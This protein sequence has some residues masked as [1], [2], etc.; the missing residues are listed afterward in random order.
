MTTAHLVSP[1]G[2]TAPIGTITWM[3]I[4]ATTNPVTQMRIVAMLEKVMLADVPVIPVTES[5][6]WYEYDTKSFT[7]WPAPGNGYAQPAPYIFPD[8]GQV[9]LRLRPKRP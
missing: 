4:A 8:W 5:V 6:D 3:E 9:L 1:Y 2:G 7:G